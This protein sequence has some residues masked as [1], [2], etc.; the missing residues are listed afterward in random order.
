MKE[1]NLL[2][3]PRRVFDQIAERRKAENKYQEILTATCTRLFKEFFFYE[4][5][6]KNTCKQFEEV[7]GRFAKKKTWKHFLKNSQEEFLNI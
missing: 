2:K 3:N 7:F 5:S 1:R 6:R 4:I